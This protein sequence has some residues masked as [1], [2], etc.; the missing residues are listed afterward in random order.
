MSCINRRDFL[1][2]T[3]VASTASIAL[4]EDASPIRPI[5]AHVH[6]WT[7]DTEKYPLA[8]GYEKQS[9]KPASFTPAELFAECKPLDVQRIVLI[10][11]SFYG[12]DNRYMIEM[13]ERHPGV[14]G[15]VA[16]VDETKPNVEQRMSRLAQKGVRGFRL[17]ANEKNTSKWMSDDGIKRMWRA[18]AEQ[19]LA[20]CLLADPESLPAIHKQC[21]KYPDTKVVIDHFARIGMSGEVDQKQLDQLLA[22]SKFDNVFVKTSA[23]YALGKKQPPH[24]ELIPMVRQLRDAYGAD[25]LMWASDCPFQLENGNSYRASIELIRDKIDFLS[26]AEKRSILETTAE[27][28]FFS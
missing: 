11:M 27:R 18:G 7:P 1:A 19:N 23:F 21:A 5:D 10:Q 26:A 13:M 14:F 8:D 15:G 6:V 16:I 20:M 12:F 9:M 22:L 17:Y 4:G 3:A 28:L 2:A 25:R 24:L